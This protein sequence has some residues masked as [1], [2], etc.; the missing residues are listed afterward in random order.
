MNAPKLRSHDSHVT[1]R[2]HSWLS[3][4]STVVPVHKTRMDVNDVA[5]VFK[6]VSSDQLYEVFTLESES[7]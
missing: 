1:C 2:S 4:E 6:E 7:K 3:N 5:F